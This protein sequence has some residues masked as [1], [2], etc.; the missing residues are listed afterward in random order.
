VNAPK[1]DHFSVKC[2]KA[3]LSAE[4]G[5]RDWSHSQLATEDSLLSK[6]ALLFRWPHVKGLGL[7]HVD[8]STLD[9][10]VHC[11]SIKNFNWLLI[12]CHPAHE[13]ICGA[14]SLLT[15]VEVVVLRAVS[16]E[17]KIWP[18]HSSLDYLSEQLINFG[19]RLVYFFKQDNDF[20]IDALFVRNDYKQLLETNIESS[21]QELNL[22]HNK[23]HQSYEENS[24]MA[25]S[26]EGLESERDQLRGKVD[27][28]TLELDALQARV[29]EQSQ[30]SSAMAQ[31]IE[32]LESERDQLKIII[33]NIRIE[34]ES[35]KT[36]LTESN[37]LNI[38]SKMYKKMFEE[39]MTKA[40]AQIDL[41][42]D[43][44]KSEMGI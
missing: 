41:M 34:L 9:N 35:S 15:D 10:V 4:G 31:S 32:G 12:D 14:T 36:Q 16:S 1:S 21:R 38:T 17:T 22:T 44:L 27:A 40:E 42:K 33:E 24:A 43:L 39:E 18:P 23:L 37:N 5:V 3:T 6:S 7:K 29:I 11:E 8:T 2:I 13:I 25:Q 28:A 19:L 26:I 30:E 20:F